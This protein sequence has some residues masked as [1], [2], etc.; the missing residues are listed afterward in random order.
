[1]NV[2]SLVGKY[3]NN[4]GYLRRYRDGLHKL[5][6]C[7]TVIRS[8]FENDRRMS[9]KGSVNEN[10]LDTNIRRAKRTV[11]ELAICNEWD[12]FVTLTI[13]SKKYCRSDLDTYRSDLMQWLR[14]YGK[15]HNIKIDYLL[16]PELHSDGT[17][18][19]LHGFIKGLPLDHLSINKNGYQDWQDY[20]NKFG[21]IS[22]DKIKDAEAC[23]RYI[24][25]Y[26]SKDLADCVKEINAKMYYCSQGLQ[27]STIEKSGMYSEYKPLN[28]DFEN[29]YAKIKWIKDE[30]NLEILKAQLL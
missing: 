28:W 2:N 14:D 15:K 24:T 6:L 18:W 22:L 23:S 27:R 1:M 29:E 20:Q 19:H 4:I 8:G 7:K 12:L 10:K 25:K 21:W 9:E 16:I 30:N 3:R 13:D 26:I 11:F 5:T 17:S